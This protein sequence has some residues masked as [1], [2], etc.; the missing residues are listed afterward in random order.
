MRK[1][2]FWVF[3]L[4]VAV[5]FTIATPPIHGQVMIE[6]T[7]FGTVTDPSGS[8]VPNA[9]VTV[10]SV[11]RGIKR[12][13]KT[14]G[15]GQYVVTNLG[16]GSYVVSV[17]AAGFKKAVNAPVE[18]TAAERIQED[19]RLQV[20]EVSQSVEVH[21]NATLVQ[22]GSA[23]VS[24]LVSQEQLR[25]LP[26][27]S[28]NLLSIVSLGAGTNSGTSSGRQAQTSGA[29]IIVNG[30]LAE[31]NNFILDGVSD[32]MEFSGTIAANP[33]IE[34]VQEV[35]LLTN[36]FSAEY[37]RSG[38][39]IINMV[40]KSGTN[41]LH[42][43]AYDYFQND[44]LNAAPYNFTGV[45]QPKLALRLNRFGAG[46]GG[47]II[48]NKLF[49]FVNYEG[50]RNPSSS[51]GQE[52][53]PTTAEKSGDF[54][55]AGFNIYDPATAH[56]DPTIPGRIDRNQFS[57]NIIPSSRFNNAGVGLL[58]Y[59]PHPNFTSPIPGVLTNYLVDLPGTNS[60]NSYDVKT[61]WNVSSKDSLSFHLTQNLIS[62][63]QDGWLPD[64]RLSTITRENGTN[65]G[66]TWTHILRPTLLNEARVAY[67]RF[68]L[69]MDNLNHDNV[70]DQYNIPGWHT[71]P[72]IGLGFPTVSITNISGAAPT[73]ELAWVGNAFHLYENVYQYLDTVSWIK[74][75]HSIKFGG[76]Y[77]HIRED[78]NQARS[79]GGS[80][81]FAPDYTTS[82]VGQPSVNPENGVPD[83]LLGLSTSLDTQY[84][85]D[86]VRDRGYRFGAFFQD[87]WRVLPKLTLN[88]GLRWDFVSP[89]HEEQDRVA[90]F[91]LAT[92]IKL[93]PSDARRVIQNTLGLPG[94]NLP[95]GYEYVPPNQVNPQP[96]YH[97]F[98]PRFGLAYRLGRNASFRAGYGI[99]YTV[100]TVNT[101][102]NAGTEGNPF[103]FDFQEI[104]SSA[105]PV[106]VANGFPSSGI[107]S[108]LSSP[109]AAAHYDPI[110]R[111]DP[112]AEKWNAHVEWSPAN[113]PILIDIGYDG[114]RG[115]FF[116]TL[117]PLNQAP[118]PGP[119]PLSQ[120]LPYPN[121]GF[122]YMYMPIADTNYNGLSVS[123]TTR[124]LHGFVLN[125]A[126]T[127]S[128]ALGYGTGT[129]NVDTYRWNYKYDYGPQPYD[130]THRWVTSATYQL[131]TLLHSAV[132][133]TVLG[134]WLTSGIMTVQT[135]YPFT[136]TDSGANNSVNVGGLG[137][138][139]HA[140]IVG[141]WHLPS[142]QRSL[143]HYF[144]TAAFT[145]PAIYTFGDSATDMLTGPGFVNLDFALEK[146]FTLPW[147]E[148]RLIVRMEASNLFNTPH[149]GNPNASLSSQAFGQ[150]RGL[151]GGSTPRQLQAVL[152][153]EF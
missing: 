45:F 58:S 48:K 97:D 99:F 88:L 8:A 93:I 29:E 67:N 85:F 98:S 140:N 109:S 82:Y 123:V 152:K 28:R 23:Q 139:N 55:Q 74:G 80:L 19:T 131:P 42:G 119:A 111:P 3:W 81:S 6:G 118:S 90:N 44:A 142:G 130:L 126:Y 9:T 1:A 21:G 147:R 76:E 4:S 50:F 94:G 51:L 150:I 68:V 117:I 36:Q 100:T 132:A 12:T 148:Q 112:Y 15:S 78:R 122:S 10:T 70:I 43:F 61:D 37:G 14:N 135:G 69:P 102:N 105:T 71:V 141:S 95:P 143:Q 5:L 24:N 2:P 11:E 86:A 114:E 144:N 41:Q 59:F 39:G 129:D 110:N 92:G 38:G 26:V 83:M 149:F 133:R 106:V 56:P 46:A 57:G 101:F 125:S 136:V 53:V 87:D 89:Y 96:Q 121:V 113:K 146:Q 137:E 18:L 17:T 73:R 72:P 35:S 138:S 22:T 49:W 30:N 40:L 27:L 79:G 153:Y 25:T 52:V 54:S 32:N 66:L 65:T 127:Y 134:G 64:N 84:S 103:F 116:P 124:N 108:V 107:E 115:L 7:I 145:A 13:T 60:S 120:T 62:Y 31:A 77:D 104:G 33:P 34:A 75:G 128:R 20:G 91:N 47:P 16:V 63:Q 151:L